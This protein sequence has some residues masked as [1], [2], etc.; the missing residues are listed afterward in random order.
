[1]SWSSYKLP[2]KYESPRKHY[3]LLYNTIIQVVI[4]N[5]VELRIARAKCLL[6]RTT[7]HIKLGFRV[8]Y[9]V[10]DRS[11]NSYFVFVVRVLLL[12]ENSEDFDGRVEIEPF[13]T[14]PALQSSNAGARLYG[15][16]SAHDNIVQR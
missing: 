3:R 7:L 12:Q 14:L 16:A 15:I 9:L 4:P 5:W 2:R 1:L 6:A 8:Q 11:L 13:R 10:D